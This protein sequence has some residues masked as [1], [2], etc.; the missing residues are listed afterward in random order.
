MTTGGISIAAQA[1][2]ESA[3]AETSRLMLS[4]AQRSHSD[5]V[6][7]GAAHIWQAIHGPEVPALA[8]AQ[9]SFLSRRR[10]PHD[11]LRP[12]RG[13]IRPVAVRQAS[14]VAEGQQRAAFEARRPQ[15]PE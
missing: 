14:D 12:Q 3:R 6:A 7:A 10:S 1:P 8:R 5:D 13:E 4:R 15:Q 2:T 11:R 9:R